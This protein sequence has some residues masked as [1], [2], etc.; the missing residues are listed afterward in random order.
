MVKERVEMDLR[1]GY[2]YLTESFQ[3]SLDQLMEKQRQCMILVVIM[4]YTQAECAEGLWIT[5]ETVK[6]HLAAP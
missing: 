5:R 1:F 6:D 3:K 2:R 4:G